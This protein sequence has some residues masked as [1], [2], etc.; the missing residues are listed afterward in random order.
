MTVLRLPSARAASVQ[1]IRLLCLKNA[2][3]DRSV[4]L[5]RR[6]LSGRPQ[7]ITFRAVPVPAGA[8]KR[9]RRP[10]RFQRYLIR[11][12]ILQAASASASAA[13]TKR[14]RRPR[15]G[16][17]AASVPRRLLCVLPPPVP[18]RARGG[19][20]EEAGEDAR[21][22][23]VRRSVGGVRGVRGDARA[24]AALMHQSGGTYRRRVITTFAR[25]ALLYA[26]FRARAL[27]AEPTGRSS[28]RSRVSSSCCSLFPSRRR[29]R[30]GTDRAVRFPC[31]GRSFVRVAPKGHRRGGARDD[32]VCAHRRAA[33]GTGRELA[34]ARSSSLSE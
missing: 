16:T 21:A 33:I 32:V 28:R 17:L 4:P 7:I 15:R 14:K 6:E 5:D 3:F 25:A 34:A 11:C 27:R 10:R 9:R 18:E 20:E 1:R 23:R 26:A 30:D 8:V 29:Q 2:Q 12:I 13:C 31:R 22:R 19:K 24:D